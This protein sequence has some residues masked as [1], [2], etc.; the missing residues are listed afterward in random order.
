MSSGV[1]D[2]VRAGGRL[3][4]ILGV[5]FGMAVC[6]GETI[7]G[8]ILV[9]PG[10]VARLGNPWLIA[11]VWTVGGVYAILG[12]LSVAE[13]GTM[14]PRAGGWYVY[15]REAFGE[16]AGFAV[17]CC[18]WMVETVA[19]AYLAVALGE[20]AARL[21]P[22]LETNA[23]A[24]ALVSLLCLGSLN[25]MGLQMGSRVQEFTSVA[26]AV[27]LVGFVLLCFSVSPHANG[28]SLVPSV[29]VHRG[30]WL[31][32]VVAALQAV[33]VTYDGWYAGIYFVEEDRNPAKNLPRSAIG[34]VLCCVAI[35]ALVNAA[36]VYVLRIP[37]LANSKTPAADAA[38]LLFGAHGQQ[39]LLGISL[40][41][42]AST[43]NATLLITPRILFGMSRDGL[44]PHAITSVN[45]G[46][47]PGPALL[48]C[49]AAAALLV[50]AGS[51]E[52]LL[53]IAAF[54]FVVVYISGFLALLFLRARRPDLPRPFRVWG[55]PWTTA[56]VL[57]ASLG[58]LVASA[59]GNVRDSLETVLFIALTYALYRFAVKPRKARAATEAA[60]VREWERS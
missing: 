39:V 23:K 45:A 40:V 25:W 7:G 30:G 6:V 28:S 55:Y 41:I 46:G 17:G 47:T 14:L 31:F 1:V 37:L 18:D 35:F 56:A 29:P 21:I 27:A 51:F 12:T 2:K 38:F 11:G 36:L 8:G 3:L 60:A 13:L 24:V 22:P 52:T 15:S 9:T 5:G 43:M 16:Y 48:L 58:F 59:I 42:L 19:L 44:L 34:G 20:A 49:T 54:L 4:R 26:K 32:A 53:G 57:L 10:E 50:L 33:I